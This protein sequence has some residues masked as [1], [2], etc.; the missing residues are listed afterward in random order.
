MVLCPP[1][2]HK[3]SS[4]MCLPVYLLSPTTPARATITQ[5]Q[6]FCLSSAQNVLGT[7]SACICYYVTLGLCKC[8]YQCLDCHPLLHCPWETPIYPSEPSPV[9]TQLDIQLDFPNWGNL[10]GSVVERLPLAQV[11]IPRSWDRVPPRAPLR[12]PASPTAYISASL[13]VSLMNE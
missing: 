6:G 9:I 10:G 11:V 12:E 5:G 4:W 13:C 8:Y 3:S 7:K 1:W 2:H